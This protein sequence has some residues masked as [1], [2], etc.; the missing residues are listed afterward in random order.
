MD[1]RTC[2]DAI[3]KITGEIS[4][5]Q[6]SIIG[7]KNQPGNHE[8]KI[9]QHKSDLDFYEDLKTKWIAKRKQCSY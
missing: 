6:A 1:K 5:I 2:N 3:T 4:R 8:A 7:L 9:K